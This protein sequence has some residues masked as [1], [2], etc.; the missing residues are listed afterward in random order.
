M[1]ARSR[2][3]PCCMMARKDNQRLELCVTV[4]VLCPVGESISGAGQSCARGLA[5]SALWSEFCTVQVLVGPQNL[6]ALRNCEVSAFRRAVKC[7]A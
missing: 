4:L 2:A 1:K 3:L 5:A 6:S 7:Y